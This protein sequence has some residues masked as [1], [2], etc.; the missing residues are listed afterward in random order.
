M[1][2]LNFRDKGGHE[3]TFKTRVTQSLNLSTLR[4]LVYV[5]LILHWYSDSAQAPMWSGLS[6]KFKYPL[7]TLYKCVNTYNVQYIL[8]PQVYMHFNDMSGFAR[9]RCKC[10]RKFLRLTRLCNDL[11]TQYQITPA[12]LVSTDGI[13]YHSINHYYAIP[14]VCLCVLISD[15]NYSVYY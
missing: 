4:H 7:N 2:F 3:G 13:W 1:C 10:K 9:D 14:Y 11:L 12:M 5:S 6:L 8:N 15:I